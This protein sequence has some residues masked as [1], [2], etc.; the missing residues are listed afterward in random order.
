MEHVLTVKFHKP[1]EVSNKQQDAPVTTT[2]LTNCGR[3]V[4]PL[5]TCSRLAAKIPAI[6]DEHGTLPPSQER[7]DGTRIKYNQELK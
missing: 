2:K 3:L 5:E 6:G 7:S 4:Q 1:Q